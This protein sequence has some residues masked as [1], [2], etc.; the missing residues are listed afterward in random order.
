[1]KLDIPKTYYSE[2]Y[3]IKI[4][5]YLDYAQIQQIANAA[6]KFD[7]WASRQ[8][9]IDMLLLYHV[10]DIPK[11]KLE[12]TKHFDLL[13]SGLIDEVYNHVA[14]VGQIE[15]AINRLESTSRLLALI[16]KAIQDG[17]DPKN[18]KK[19]IDAIQKVVL[20]ARSDK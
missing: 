16:F 5:E 3:D 13:R 12:N 8:S 10:T 20:D 11:D 18:N 2:K 17:L 15:E 6:V 4:N 1:M 7:D 19:F 9:N 14:N